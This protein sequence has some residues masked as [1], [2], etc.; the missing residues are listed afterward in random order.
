MGEVSGGRLQS[1]V[2]QQSRPSCLDHPMGRFTQVSTGY[3]PDDATEP[4]RG[5]KLPTVETK[6]GHVVRATNGSTTEV[7]GRQYLSCDAM[8]RVAGEL[9][10][11]TEACESLPAVDTSENSTGLW[12]RG[13]TRSRCDSLATMGP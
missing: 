9:V 5:P 2:G 13:M 10:I 11:A 3:L 1:L 12:G 7:M 4:S 6:P 8:E